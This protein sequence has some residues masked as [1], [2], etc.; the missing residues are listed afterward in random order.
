MRKFMCAAFVAVISVAWGAPAATAQNVKAGPFVI[1]NSSGKAVKFTDMTY[2]DSTGTERKITDATWEIKA[3]DFSRLSYNDK[4]INA[5]KVK[6]T[7]ITDA[8]ST[9]LTWASN[10]LD[11]DG[12]MVGSLTRDDIDQHL[13]LLGKTPPPNPNAQ[14][15]ANQAAAARQEIAT[16]IADIETTDGRIRTAENT[17]DAADLVYRFAEAGSN[18]EL[19]A[20]RTYQ[21]AEIAIVGFQVYRRSLE[22]KLR[23]AQSRLAGL[24]D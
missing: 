11:A 10:G 5:T 9:T 1:K 14:L 8:G 6:V 17:R 24:Q 22:S 21:A 23:S 2:T 18:T 3:G 19:I 4:T 13:R 7:L 12:D 16:I 20:K 15:R